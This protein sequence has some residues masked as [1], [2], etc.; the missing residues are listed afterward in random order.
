VNALQKAGMNE[1]ADE[2]RPDLSHYEDAE[3]SNLYQDIESAHDQEEDTP[4]D[5]G[6]ADLLNDVEF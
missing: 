6:I 2:L 1:V 4:E 5:A 3:F